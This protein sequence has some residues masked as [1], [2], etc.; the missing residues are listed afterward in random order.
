MI[1]VHDS[2]L[3]CAVHERFRDDELIVRRLVAL[4]DTIRYDTIRHDG[5]YLP[6]RALKR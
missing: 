4:Q 2:S 6:V 1:V 3:T 5:L